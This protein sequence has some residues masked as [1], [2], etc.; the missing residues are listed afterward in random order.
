MCDSEPSGK[1]NAWTE[2]AKVSADALTPFSCP[3]TQQEPKQN[4]FLLRIIMQLKPEGKGINW[5]SIQMP[6]RTVKSLQNQWTAVNKK[7]ELI[8]S[9]QQNGEANV[10]ATPKKIANGK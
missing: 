10:P 9:Q 8:K 2:E 7:I 3:F 1:A 4:E 5:G 6:G